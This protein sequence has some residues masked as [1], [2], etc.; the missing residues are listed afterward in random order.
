MKD[1]VLARI[2]DRLIH[3]QVMTKWLKSTQAEN[4]V[5]VDDDVSKDDFMINV[6]ESAVP[7]NI[8]I[9]VFNKQDAVKFFS[10][11]LPGPTILLVKVPQTIK[12]M[13]DNGIDIPEV[14][15]GGMGARQDRKT[16]YQYI[17]TNEDEDQVFLDLVKQGV[18]VFVQI[19]PQNDKLPI[20]PLID[21]KQNS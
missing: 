19:V 18:N 17:S 9:G 7:D 13:I 11:P 14:D 6:F 12:Y 1:L 10:E 15:L 21:R 5:I 2:D 3:G 4:V 16:L 8:G 20:K